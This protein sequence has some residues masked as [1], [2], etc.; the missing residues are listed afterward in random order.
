[1]VFAENGASYGDRVRASAAAGC[2]GVELWGWRDKPLPEI[3][4]AAAETGVAVTRMLVDPPVGLVDA[5][6]RDEFVASVRESAAAAGSIGC[7][8]LGVASGA[9]RAGASSS[10]QDKAIVSTLRAAAPVAG[11]HGVRLLLE[12]LN[13][14]DHPNVYLS[15]TTHGLDLVERVDAPEVG[16]L[17]DV[18]HSATMDEEPAEVLDGRVTLIGHVHVADTGG[19]HEPGTGTIDWPRFVELLREVGYRGFLGLEYFP[20]VD[21][22][23]SIEPLRRLLG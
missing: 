8:T 13:R 22:A 2:E 20:T 12:P 10:E 6:C 19:R 17:Y 4:D 21:S 5:S 14:V 16:L 9:M 11:E 23:A 18:Y 1:M 7:G 15:A 3:A